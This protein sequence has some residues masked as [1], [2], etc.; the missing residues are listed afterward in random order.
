METIF[1]TFFLLAVLISSLC[2]DK[3]NINFNA[4]YGKDNFHTKGAVRFASLVKDYSNGT[5]NIKVFDNSYLTKMDNLRAVQNGTVE[6]AD[7]L[8]PLTSSGE[9]LFEISALPF[10]VTSYDNAYKLYQ[11]SKPAYEKMMEKFNQKF[12]YST[13]WPVSGFY[14]N[15]KITSIGDFKDMKTRTY[16]KNTVDFIKY[17]GGKAIVLPWAEVNIALK[18]NMV[19]SVITSST[20]GNDGKFWEVLSNFTKI[21]YAFPL[22]AVTI[23]LDSWN[24]M[25]KAQQDAILKAA[26]VIE[27]IQWDAVKIED[28]NALKKMA[29]NGMKISNID[30]KLKQELNSIA[31]K[32]L[33]KYLD[34]SSSEIKYIF[35]QYKKLDTSLTQLLNAKY[36]AHT[37][38]GDANTK[39]KLII[40]FNNV[41]C[42]TFIDNIE[43]LKHSKS[44]KEFKTNLLYT[45]YKD[46]KISYQTRKHFFS[47][48]VTFNL[49]I[50]DITC[51]LGDCQKTTK[52]LNNKIDGKVYLKEIPIVKREIYYIKPQDINLSKLSSGDYVGIYTNID[53]LD[54][55]HTGLIV[56][57]NGLVY[58]RHASSIQKKVVDVLFSEY[59]STK[60]GVIIYQSI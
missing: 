20:S 13:V 40:D 25:D 18:T 10:I 49:N 4:K 32:I 5:I 57:K 48:W 30:D 35:K 39:E 45:R 36:K 22:Q 3:V 46:S 29:K 38:I 11:I 23:N 26:K 43:A 51:T 6:M 19:N 34:N 9:K 53:G 55:T 21:N 52:Y 41:D 2:A 8:M 50:K 44:F 31:K 24:S 27:E 14:S 42:L 33:D 37:L 60:A 1:K 16:D 12:L 54:V 28:K 7:M 17:A 59:I 58:L 56:L 15:K 47:D